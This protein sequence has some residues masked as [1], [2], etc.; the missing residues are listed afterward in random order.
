MEAI[1][2]DQTECF[3]AAIQFARTEGIVPAPEPTHA[4]AATMAEAL[5]CKASGEEKVI[6]TALCGH[7]LLDL[8]AYEAYLG[9]SMIDSGLSDTDLASAL[10]AVPRMAG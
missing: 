5:A 7:G 4:L 1:A 2:I 3:A 8:A 10:A 6:V 9:G